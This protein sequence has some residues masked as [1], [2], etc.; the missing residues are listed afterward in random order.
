M[1]TT[2]SLQSLLSGIAV[3]S[4]LIYVLACATSFSPDDRQVIYPSFDP[5]SGASSVTLYDR[6]TGRTETLL[7]SSL[8]KGATNQESLLLRAEWMPDGKHILVGQLV[9]D[10]TLLLT[11]LPRGVAEPV[12]NYTLTD[13]K[14]VGASLQ[15][16]FAIAGHQLFLNLDKADPTRVDLMTGAII[17]G[18]SN[19]NA[20]LVLPM[21]GGKQLIGLLPNPTNENIV[22][23][24]TYDPET[25]HFQHIRTLPEVAG[26]CPLPYFNPASGQT[27]R[28]IKTNS[29]IRLQVFQED[30]LTLERPLELPG[31]HVQASQLPDVSPNG[32]TA[33]LAACVVTETKTNSTYGLL[34]VPL[35]DAPLRFT[36]LFQANVSDDGDLL[37]AQPA[38]AHDGRTWA[39]CSSYI[40]QQNAS[41]RPE[42]CA[43]FL[44]DV[45]KAKRPVTKVP[46]P[47]PPQREKLIR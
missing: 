30:K 14:D 42:D 12:R 24:G 18:Q 46:V 33:Y 5:Q 28:L 47:V 22:S 2:P 16:P 44:V 27:L 17:A 41:L 25:R 26:D 9:A 35:T 32:R 1:K 39:I 38:L 23:V 43:L 19:L 29:Q 10:D 4:L 20:V 45:S 11:V 6:D 36:P 21:P 13:M 7:V 37:L 8:S 40:Y 34:E 3:G 15:F 31:G